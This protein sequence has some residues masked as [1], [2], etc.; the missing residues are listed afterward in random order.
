MT[1]SDSTPVAASVPGW[2][3]RSREMTDTL[4][5][6]L[7]DGFRATVPHLWAGAAVPAG[8]FWCLAPDVFA[9][10]HLGDDGHPARGVVMPPVPF[11]RRMWAG[12]ELV[13]HGTF[14]PGDTVR[15]VTTIAD[16]AEKSGQSGRLAFV[17]VEH[18]YFVGADLV[19][20][21]RQDIVYRDAAGA[22]PRRTQPPADPPADGV[23]SRTVDTDPV[24]LF[25]YSALTF[26]GHRIHYDAPYAR[27]VEGY[28]GLVVH[29]PLQATL[30]LNLAAQT[31]GRMPRK[32]G[33]RGKSPLICGA[34][35]TIEAAPASGGLSARCVS[36]AGVTTFTAAVEG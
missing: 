34:P 31:L 26:N 12:G 33:Y 19:L 15:K 29:G 9:A 30:L 3:G 11:E 7:L 28:D 25:R 14:R 8:A 32:F 22:G 24:L 13:F 17:T 5:P 35:F 2:I 27:Q 23:V 20:N 4:S 18:E 10:A 1:A 6:R 36:A 21:E 16:I